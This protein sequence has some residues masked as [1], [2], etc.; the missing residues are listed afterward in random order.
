MRNISVKLF[1]IWT[2]DSWGDI[3]Y[4]QLFWPS[5]LV[6]RTS[7]GNFGRGNYEEHSVKLFTEMVQEIL[8]R[9]KHKN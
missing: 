4:I 6:G 7:L 1:C 3:S 8:C 5:Y 2:S 9:F